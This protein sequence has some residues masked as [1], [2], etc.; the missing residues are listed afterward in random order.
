MVHASVFARAFDAHH[1]LRL[2]DHADHAVVAAWI[3]TYRAW[4]G[5]AHVAADVAEPYFFLDFRDGVDQCLRFLVGHVEQVEGDA[6]RAFRPDAGQ[7]GERVDESLDG[8][9][10]G[11][12][13][14]SYLSLTGCRS[15]VPD[16]WRLMASP[17]TRRT[18]SDMRRAVAGVSRQVFS[19]PACCA[20]YADRP[21]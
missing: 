9:V 14:G 20:D 17:G 8:A 10:I 12:S 11:Q 6:L 18:I 7:V 1:V 15:H 13:H 16:N 2:F 3:N 21:S 4:A 19:S 5:F